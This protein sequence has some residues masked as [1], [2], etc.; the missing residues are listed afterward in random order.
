MDSKKKQ[1]VCICQ[2]FPK[3]NLHILNAP[4]NTYKYFNKTISG[5]ILRTL[6]QEYAEDFHAENM[7]N[8]SEWQLAYVENQ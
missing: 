3:T 5:S 8:Q 1:C 2:L 4:Q 6:I 7:T